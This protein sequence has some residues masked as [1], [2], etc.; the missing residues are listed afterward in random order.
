MKL[1]DFF[2]K[3]LSVKVLIP[4]VA[5][6][7]LVLGVII[8]VNINNQ[9]TSQMA[10]SQEGAENMA[11]AIE[12]GM[13]DALSIGDNDVVLKQFD[14][15]K[16]NMALLD[17][18]IFDFTGDVTFATD[19]RLIG[20]NVSAYSVEP[21][22]VQ[23]IQTM[24]KLGEKPKQPIQ[25][26]LDGVRYLNI[27]KPIYNETR[28]FHC[29]GRSKKILG[30]MQVRTPIEN[31]L[32]A[33]ASTR[34]ISIIGGIIG[35]SI[36]CVI[37]FGLLHVLIRLPVNRLLELGGKMRA[38]DL[39]QRVTVNGRDEISHM[40]ARMNLVNESLQSMIHGIVDSSHTLSEGSASQAASLE[41]TS[42]SINKMASIVKKNMDRT[43]QS[44][45][46][47]KK[48]DQIFSQSKISIEEVTAAM[49]AITKA[50]QETSQIIKTIDEIAFQTNLLALNASVEAARAGEAGAGF[51]VVA[52]E[53]RNLALRAAD[54]AK[55]TTGLIDQIESKI[56]IGSD[57]VKETNSN[58]VELAE[59]IEN[60][61]H[62][63]SEIA[64]ASNDQTQGIEQIS[65]AV[66]LIDSATQQN[67]AM[68]EEL[69]ASADQFI[70]DAKESTNTDNENL[71]SRPN[72][73][74]LDNF[75]D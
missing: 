65:Q 24:L 56:K 69:A 53:V 60:S 13:I 45:E 47:M 75:T 35:V 31:V 44:N 17:V 37:V 36:L 70:V 15:L 55:S 54:A 28:C 16:E 1:I 12:G 48:A 21:A 41:E 4:I 50:S 2:T 71:N 26:N 30:G 59:K 74:G 38:G 27:V 72:P 25:E 6:Q 46:L 23:Q 40:S 57:R 61:G 11:L 7:V 68:A 14:R 43:K 32:Q 73:E 29:H 3:N 58:F 8:F 20:S 18:M 42:E 19:K 51:A 66:A 10:I 22:V 5:A 63:I 52:D 49:E 64:A 34:N 9:H 33:S 67:A 62:L 39:T